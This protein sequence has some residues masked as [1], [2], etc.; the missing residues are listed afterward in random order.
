MFCRK[1]FKNM[2]VAGVIGIKAICDSCST[3]LADT[4]MHSFWNLW[5]EKF[6]AKLTGM[7]RDKKKV[8]K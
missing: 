7:F 2:E 4:I 1:K 3:Q 5:D 8:R 6:D